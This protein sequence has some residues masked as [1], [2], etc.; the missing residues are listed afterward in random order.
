MDPLWH[1]EEAGEKVLVLE[2][3]LFDRFPVSDMTLDFVWDL[4]RNI[5]NL[6]LFVGEFSELKNK[7][8]S[9]AKFYFKEHPTNLHYTGISEDRDWMFPEVRGYF[10]S[11]FSY[12][13][14]VEKKY[15]EN[16]SGHPFLF[17]DP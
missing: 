4:G 12:W 9:E 8:S 1:K 14:K 13:K 11:F 6:K 16:K 3:K 15:F 17:P 10:P 5:P 7:F 2:P